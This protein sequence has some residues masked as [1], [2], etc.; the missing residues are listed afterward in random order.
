MGPLTPSTGD[1]GRKTA[2]LKKCQNPKI[3]GNREPFNACY[4][5]Q[6]VSF[7]LCLFILFNAIYGLINL[8]DV[9]NKKVKSLTTPRKHVEVEEG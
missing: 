4:A 6:T 8:Q 3:H 9:K 5:V 1:S 7:S 2:I